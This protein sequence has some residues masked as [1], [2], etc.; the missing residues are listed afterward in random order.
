MNNISVKQ[1]L[2]AGFGVL[3]VSVAVMGVASVKVIS[4]IRVLAFR[5]TQDCL[6]GLYTAGRIRSMTLRNRE[7]LAEIVATEDAARRTTL[8]DAIASTSAAID[9]EI[10]G[11]DAT[12]TTDEDRRLYNEVKATRAAW[13]SQRDAVIALAKEG[14]L[15]QA[16]ELF[17]GAARAALNGNVDAIGA[18]F[19]L[20]G[21]QGMLVSKQIM[22]AVSAATTATWIA[23][24]LAVAFGI[25]IAL[26]ISRSIAGGIATLLDH[27]VRV[28][29]GDLDSRATYSGRDEIGQLA[30]ELNRM[31][32]EIK[33]ARDGDRGR[34]DTEEAIKRELQGKVNAILA[35]VQSVANGDLT[36]RVSVS[37]ADSV[38]QLGE[39]FGQLISDLHQNMS[40]IARNAQSLASSADELTASSQMMAANS[41][42]TSVQAAT[43]SSAA[44]QVSKNV[45]TVAAGADE[46]T[47]SIKEIARNAHEA[48]R[49]ATSAVRVAEVT[50]GTISKLGESSIEIGKV[51]KVITSIAEQTNLLALNATIEAARAGEAGKGFAVVANEVKELAKETAK[52]TEDISH[53]IDTIQSDTTEAVKAIKEIRVI[54]GQV[55][56]IST[57]IAGAV[58]E[59]TSTTNEIGRSVAQAAQGA[60]D[61]ARNIT[62]VA[63]SAR[64]TAS[65]ATQTQAASGALSQMAGELQEMVSRFRLDGRAR[66]SSS[67]SS[68][69]SP[70][71]SASAAGGASSSA[72]ST[73]ARA[74]VG[75]ANGASHAN[76]NGG[77]SAWVE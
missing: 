2:L 62:G 22:T 69:P 9:A 18:L 35:A 45:S 19:E 15:A 56:D 77:G 43:V 66:T 74:A 21:S 31:T 6:S 33:S 10:S 71:P 73:S 24:A 53:K 67:S 1:R 59:Q 47:A 76:G 46:M 4:D 26:A 60:A 39:G 70:S 34:A 27:V 37:G 61:I 65:G 38:G 25:G 20:N 12:V 49:V 7:A 3:V 52:A 16:R 23:M 28:A 32:D 48:A 41:E 8:I 40:A 17:L 57:T 50:S 58:E 36:Q 72:R 55:N 64:N 42:E 75:L 68:S 63:D 30:G 44:E 29:Q 51:I 14:K 5:V 54:I 11:Y 13:V